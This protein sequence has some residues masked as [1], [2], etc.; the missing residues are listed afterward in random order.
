MAA[1]S[2][3]KE[4]HLQE[5]P[6]PPCYPSQEELLLPLPIACHGNESVNARPV[7][8]GGEVAG[9]TG[10]CHHSLVHVFGRSL[11]LPAGVI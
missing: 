2:P 4:R 5:K 7:T 10:G 11:A 6:P 1:A 9:L 3:S 8:Q